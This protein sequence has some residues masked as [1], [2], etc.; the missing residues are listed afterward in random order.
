MLGCT[1][2]VVAPRSL[3]FLSIEWLWQTQ[4]HMVREPLVW[5]GF[6]ILLCQ[7]YDHT[8]QWWSKIFNFGKHR[9]WHYT[10]IPHTHTYYSINVMSCTRAL[11]SILY[12][13]INSAGEGITATNGAVCSRGRSVWSASFDLDKK[14]RAKKKIYQ[15]SPNFESLVNKLK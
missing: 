5:G 7:I 15:R 4:V 14:E 1:T 12:Q 6:N 9:K 3:V 13:I 11:V 8:F 2:I 10:Y